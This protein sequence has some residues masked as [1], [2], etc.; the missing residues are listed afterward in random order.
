M[1]LFSQARPCHHCQAQVGVLGLCNQH[2]QVP[3][4]HP[5]H[6]QRHLQEV[7]GISSCCGGLSVARIRPGLKGE[8]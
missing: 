4:D 5:E 3:Q 6:V 8:D 2:Q 1:L 7:K